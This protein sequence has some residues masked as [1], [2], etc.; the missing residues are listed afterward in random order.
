MMRTMLVIA[1]VLTGFATVRSVEAATAFNIIDLGTLGGSDSWGYGLNNSNE[2]VGQAQV[3]GPAG[4]VRFPA[5]LED[6]LRGLEP[7]YGGQ[8]GRC[9]GQGNQQRE[10]TSS[11][12]AHSIPYRVPGWTSTISSYGW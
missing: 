1:M 12:R 10:K 11:H 2:A 4:P 6:D 7:Q 5:L 3:P 9:A 8:G